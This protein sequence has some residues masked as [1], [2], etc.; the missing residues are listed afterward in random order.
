MKFVRYVGTEQCS[1]REYQQAIQNDRD[2]IVDW[3]TATANSTVDYRLD[4]KRMMLGISGMTQDYL[5]LGILVYLTDEMVDR[6]R[7]TDYWTR[8]IRCLIPVNDPDRWRSRDQLLKETLSVLSGDLWE[9][10]WVQLNGPPPVRS[11]RLTLPADC[12]TVCLFSGGIDSL[13][14]AAQLLQAGRKLLLVGHQADGQTSSAQTTLAAMLRQL[15]PNQLHL[16]Q[17]RVA[18]SY[19]H[20]PQFHLAAKNEISHR[21]RSFLFLALGVAIAAKC[22]IN[23]IFMPENGFMA[24]NIPI[25]K[26]RTGS[27]STRTAHPLYM[28]KFL[29]LASDVAGFTGSIRNPFLTQSKTDMLRSFPVT[30]KPLISRS[31]SCSRPARY[32]NLG[33]HHCGYC[34]PC[35]HRRIAMSEANLDL[36]GHYAFDVFRDFSNIDRDKQQ[37]FR[38]V[39]RFAMRV[40]SASAT[41]LQTLVLSHGHFPSN[42][43]SMIGVAATTN[44]DP[45]VDMLRRWA[46][47]FIS[48]VQSKASDQTRRALGLA[49][50]RQRGS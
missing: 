48:K 44:Y 21:P 46:S 50:R 6:D 30:L 9:F 15:Y 32:N 11:H 22:G 8:N 1:D 12:D 43:G 13:L 38:A 42:V 28:L 45:W 34:V 47:D 33:V 17:C 49:I 7:T 37:D 3:V 10:E 18:R 35:I 16:L 27:L 41:E 2:I 24:L 26:S 23:E 40:E 4:D 5:D 29:Q 19:R 39:V 25:Q 14:G 20:S 31:I 36:P